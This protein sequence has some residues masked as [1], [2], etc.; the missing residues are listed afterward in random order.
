MA[1]PPL[2]D[3]ERLL[4]RRLARFLTI[5][6]IIAGV[7]VAANWITSGSIRNYVAD[8]FRPTSLLAV[9]HFYE[10]QST[11]YPNTTI[12]GNSKVTDSINITVPLRITNAIRG[13][14]KNPGALL[15]KPAREG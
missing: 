8:R 10:S 14:L 1:W 11:P 6:L 3:I 5:V 9:T 2:G 12:Y 7:V 13:C 4:G 15:R